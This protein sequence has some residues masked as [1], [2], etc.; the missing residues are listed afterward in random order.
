MIHCLTSFTLYHRNVQSGITVHGSQDWFTAQILFPNDVRANYEC[1]TYLLAQFRDISTRI[2]QAERTDNGHFSL[3]SYTFTLPAEP[4]P[5]FSLGR[6]SAFSL[7]PSSATN[8][9]FSRS[10]PSSIFSLG[11]TSAF[12][13]SSR[14]PTTTPVTSAFSFGQSNTPNLPTTTTRQQSNSGGGGPSF[15]PPA[16]ESPFQQTRD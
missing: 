10:G 6:T 1:L 16:A 5:T 11:R 7:P 4:T 13:P 15:C 2:R 14:K 3:P 9:Q 8:Q 12:S